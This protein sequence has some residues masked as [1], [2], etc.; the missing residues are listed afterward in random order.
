[1]VGDHE[2]TE[3]VLAV[4]SKLVDDIGNEKLRSID[5]LLESA[6]G[7]MFCVFFCRH[8]TECEGRIDGASSPHCHAV[9]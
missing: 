8:R 9:P 5:S 3:A 2:D 1:M 7:F 4:I 6:M